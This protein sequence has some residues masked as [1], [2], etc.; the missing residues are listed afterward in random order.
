MTLKQ[1]LL[2]QIDA[3]LAQ[4][5]MPATTF[6]RLAVNDGNFVPRLRAGSSITLRTHDRIASFLKKPPPTSYGNAP[7][8]QA[9][10]PALAPIIRQ[11]RACRSELERSG[12]V[13]AAIFGS[14]ARGDANAESDVDILIELAPDS[15]I[16][17]FKLTGLKR[18]IADLVS[19][20]DI[21]ERRSLHPEIAQ[22]ILA[23]AVYA[24]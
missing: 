18:R 1:E 4:T 8:V 5:G 22:R 11:L 20:A 16:G 24:F 3:Y 21:V 7:S 12:I 10:T 6:G 17:L 13:H 2:K 9:A 14:V 23:E 15:Q 19:H